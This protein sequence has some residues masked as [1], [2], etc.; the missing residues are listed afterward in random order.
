MSLAPSLSELIARARSDLRMGMPV[1]LRSD[2]GAALAIAAEDLSPARLDDLRG[3]GEAFL[4]ITAR[5]AETLSARAYDDDLARLILPDN[6]DVDWI[7][8]VA[9]PADDLTHPMKGPFQS[10]RGG[11]AQCARAAIALAKSARLLP[12][13][14]MVEIDN[15]YELA[16]TH[17]LTLL[18]VEP[19]L[20]L[21]ADLAPLH[22]MIH[23]RVPLLAAEKS[24]VHVF[25]PDDGGEEH[26]VVEV[27]R[28]AANPCSR[29]CI[30]PVLPAIFSA[31]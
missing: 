18:P 14:V 9:N 27:V 16:A 7:E 12:A 2:S 15:A 5:R 20:P 25:R 21:M 22:D 17:G 26:Y 28:I 10:L 19:A 3:L 4:A 31:R 24:R 29:A 8:A 23:A 11:K 13:A 30:P 1:V 6:V